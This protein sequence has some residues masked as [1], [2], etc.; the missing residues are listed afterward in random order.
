[1]E[2]KFISDFRNL[3]SIR[4]ILFIGKHEY[5]SLT[6]SILENRFLYLII[7]PDKHASYQKD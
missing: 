6:K 5:C 2:A 3:H 1:M 7:D 4:K